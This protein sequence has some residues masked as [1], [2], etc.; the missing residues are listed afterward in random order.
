MTNEEFKEYFKK[1]TKEICYTSVEYLM[2]KGFAVIFVGGLFY[3]QI[4]LED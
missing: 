4:Y 1:L 3:E 2:F